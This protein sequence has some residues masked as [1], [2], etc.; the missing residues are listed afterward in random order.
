MTLREYT[1]KLREKFPANKPIKV[2][3]KAGFKDTRL[4]DCRK[5]RKHYLIR[6]N[7]HS[8][9]YVQ[10]DTLDHEWAHCLTGMATID[11]DWRWGILYAKI[12]RHMVGE[13]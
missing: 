8:P 2:V 1:D 11:H 7:R 12:Y 4:G 9:L 10:K 3:R 5:L 13:C 6:I